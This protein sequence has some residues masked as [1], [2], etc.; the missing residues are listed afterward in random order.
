MYRK[1]TGNIKESIERG[2]FV[3]KLKYLSSIDSVDIDIYIE[4]RWTY[5]EDSMFD[6]NTELNT[7]YP[8]QNVFPR[9]VLI[10]RGCIISA[11]K[12]TTTILLSKIL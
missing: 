3:K 8:F 10:N 6:I 12:K 4:K 7:N 5:S 1:S 11:V 2:V 9:I